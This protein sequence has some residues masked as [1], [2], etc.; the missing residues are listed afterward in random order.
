MKIRRQLGGAIEI[1][2]EGKL[3]TLQVNEIAMP[4]QED[5]DGIRITAKIGQMRP[6]DQCREYDHWEYIR[7]LTLN[8][9]KDETM[10]E[11]LTGL[12]TLFL[13]LAE[14]F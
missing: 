7:T 10:V 5:L 3:L 14:S 9:T 13:K 1:I 4:E 12:S 11:T 8:I 6:A 2:H